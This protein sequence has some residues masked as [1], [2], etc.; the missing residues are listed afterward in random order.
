MSF[1]ATGC[2]ITDI[3]TGCSITG[4]ATNGASPQ[5]VIRL[6]EFVSGL[7]ED[8]SGRFFC[9]TSVVK[10]SSYSCAGSD[11]RTVMVS[12]RTGEGVVAEFCFLVTY[13]GRVVQQLEVG[14]KVETVRFTFSRCSSCMCADAVPP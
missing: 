5:D 7:S 13:A 1:G 14:N 12:V 11:G 9:G 10:W 8:V 2:G 6:V 4:E 3:I